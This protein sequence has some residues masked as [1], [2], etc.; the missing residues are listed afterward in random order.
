MI[1]ENFFLK[2]VVTT[3]QRKT[4]KGRVVE[5]GNHMTVEA[6]SARHL[7]PHE[8]QSHHKKH[9]VQPKHL[10]HSHDLYIKNDTKDHLHRKIEIGNKTADELQ[11]GTQS[12]NQKMS[13][14]L[15]AIQIGYRAPTIEGEGGNGNLISKSVHANFDSRKKWRVVWSSAEKAVVQAAGGAHRI[16][17]KAVSSIIHVVRTEILPK[18]GTLPTLEE[19]TIAKISYLLEK[20]QMGSGKTFIR[21]YRKGEI[22]LKTHGIIDD[23]GGQIAHSVTGTGQR[24]GPNS[25][26]VKSLYSQFS[27]TA[28]MYGTTDDVR[29]AITR[30][31]ERF[32]SR[33]RR[34]LQAQGAMALM[35]DIR[36][37][38]LT[39]SSSSSMITGIL[40][41]PGYDNVIQNSNYLLRGRKT[42]ATG[43][44]AIREHLGERGMLEYE[45]LLEIANSAVPPQLSAS[46]HA[47]NH[48]HH[49]D[50]NKTRV[51]Q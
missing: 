16:N 3:R 11:E 44:E 49:H 20:H 37:F 29:D 6:K 24:F 36:D 26:Y 51:N 43:V 17:P 23:V 48:H 21:L 28:D 25:E 10:H 5:M 1:L 15:T 45:K 9:V 27:Q 41:Q 40:N 22:K 7:S 31:R 4:K 30:P 19:P 35:P 42:K 8:K 34:L 13:R 2:Q 14:N 47:V 39:D 12:V 46:F 38:A 50:H 18:N 33:P 32:Q